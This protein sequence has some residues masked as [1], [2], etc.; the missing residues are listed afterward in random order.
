MESQYQT[1]GVIRTCDMWCVGCGYV[2][3]LTQLV[4]IQ[5][6]HIHFLLLLLLT[7]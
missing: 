7:A 1:S 5:M 2:F 4:N 3:V 6:P